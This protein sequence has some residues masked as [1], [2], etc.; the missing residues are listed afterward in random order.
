MVPALIGMDVMRALG[1]NIDNQNNE[2]SIKYGKEEV[3]VKHMTQVSAS[4]TDAMETQ[5]LFSINL[6]T[7]PQLNP[8]HYLVNPLSKP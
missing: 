5:Q 8:L 4:S 6:F 1:L 3:S 7:S 2:I